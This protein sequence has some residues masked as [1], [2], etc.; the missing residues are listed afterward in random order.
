MG[1]S[2]KKRTLLRIFVDYKCEECHK[3]EEEVGELE[4]HRIKPRGEYS[5]RN[6]KMVCNKCHDIFSS[7]LRKARGIQWKQ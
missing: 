3:N 4:P 7:A 6:I 1:L 5:L 2:K